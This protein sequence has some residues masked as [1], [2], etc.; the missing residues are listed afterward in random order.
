MADWEPYNK[1][2]LS[3]ENLSQ[4]FRGFERVLISVENKDGNAREN[5][6]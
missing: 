6:P 3:L 5:I 1:K 2:L 4:L